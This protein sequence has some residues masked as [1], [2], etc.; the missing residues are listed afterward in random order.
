MANMTHRTTFALDEIT[1][2]R[3]KRLAR[4]WNVSQA[5]VVRRS[6]ERAEKASETPQADAIT[7]L[8][9]LHAQ[10]GGIDKARADRWIEDIREDRKRWRASS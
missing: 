5:E 7:L 9:E 4:L 3:L 1:A 10:G 6:V 2:H 8:K